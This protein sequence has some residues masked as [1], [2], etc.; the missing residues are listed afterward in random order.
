MFLRCEVEDDVTRLI[1]SEAVWIE[2]MARK[3][4]RESAHARAHVKLE[5][6]AIT[7]RLPF[8]WSVIPDTFRTETS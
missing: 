5:Y 4:K 2:R 1:Q 7:L 8:V 6:L 3:T